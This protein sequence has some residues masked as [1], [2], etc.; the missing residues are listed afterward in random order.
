MRAGIDPQRDV[1]VVAVGTIST[2]LAALEQRQ[3]DGFAMGT[4]TPEGLVTN[5]FLPR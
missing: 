3:V 2:L 4:P 5:E 1:D